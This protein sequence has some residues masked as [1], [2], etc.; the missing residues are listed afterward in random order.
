MNQAVRG[1]LEDSSLVDEW[2]PADYIGQDVGLSRREAEVLGFVVCGF[3]NQDIAS[4]LFLSINSVKT[5][6]RSA[7]RKIGVTTRSQAVAIGM[8]LGFVR[9]EVGT[10]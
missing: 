10:E 6:I 9:G 8:E 1:T 3:S 2:E 4:S 7:Y 5:Y